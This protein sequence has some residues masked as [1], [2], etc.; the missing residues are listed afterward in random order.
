MCNDRA[1]RELTVSRA[2]AKGYIYMYAIVWVQL[3]EDNWGGL[4]YIHNLEWCMQR[5]GLGV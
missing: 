4:G 2:G 1:E 3:Y 5:I